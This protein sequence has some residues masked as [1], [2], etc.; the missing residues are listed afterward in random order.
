MSQF[1]LDKLQIDFNHDSIS[2]ERKGMLDNLVQ[3]IRKEG[4]S[5][6]LALNFICT[7]NSRRSQISQIWCQQ[8]A[9]HFGLRISAFSGGIEVTAFNERAVA[10]MRRIGMQVIKRGEQNPTY[11]ITSVAGY[12]PIAAYSKM[13]DAI[14]NPQK[15]F[16]AVMTCD[17]ADQNC[18]LIM[19]AAARIS[20]PYRDPK[21]ADDTAEE[22]SA[23]DTA[24]AVIGNELHYVFSRITN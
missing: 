24:V 12:T 6:P 20:L 11:L 5:R 14:E 19:G 7:H 22:Q 17:H 23:Y 16:L 1:V 8:L 3:T 4:R 15:G 21:Y 9:H 18:P 2:S 13:Y 10:A